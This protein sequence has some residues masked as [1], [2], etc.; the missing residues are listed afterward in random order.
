MGQI[1]RL[2][3]SRLPVNK[4]LVIESLPKRLSSEA[5]AVVQR[6]LMERLEIM[7]WLLDRLSGPRK[8]SRIKHG[9]EELLQTTPLPFAQ[10]PLA[11]LGP[12]WIR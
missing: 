10:G 9:L 7:P 4:S 2:P 11:F 3:F 12:F 1:A 8:Q 5:V 6:E